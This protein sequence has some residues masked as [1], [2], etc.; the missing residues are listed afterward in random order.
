MTT[1]ATLIQHHNITAESTFDLT[2]FNEREVWHM[3]AQGIL[4]Y[5]EADHMADGSTLIE[6]RAFIAAWDCNCEICDR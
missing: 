3:A 4:T 2:K 6:A 5:D 1:T